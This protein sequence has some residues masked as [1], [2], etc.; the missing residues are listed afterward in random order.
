VN[1]D[2]FDDV[3]M[4]ADDAAP[5]GRP[6]AGAVYVIFGKA[7][8]FVSV[9]LAGF[10]PSDSMGFIMQ[11]PGGGDLL[12]SSVSGAGDVNGDGFDDVIM[13]APYAA[14]NGRSKAGA[15]YVI[16]GKAGGFVAVD[17]A[18]FVPSNSTGF[19]VQ[20]A[21]FVDNLGVSVSGTGDMNND[22]FVGVIMGASEA[23]SKAGAVYVLTNLA[24]TFIRAPAPPDHSPHRLISAEIALRGRRLGKPHCKRQCGNYRAGW[25]RR[26]GCWS[27]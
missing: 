15:V 16:L 19:I 18:I 9:D 24:E 11:G 20:G 1:G 13:G 3:I 23:R 10:V 22:G 26:P 8:G 14:P 27:E 25:E 7:G 5:N 2:G 17:L 12:G 4:G 21:A 6:A